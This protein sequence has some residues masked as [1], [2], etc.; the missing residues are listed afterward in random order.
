MVS[1][2]KD[3]RRATPPIKSLRDR[4]ARQILQQC[5]YDKGVPGWDQYYGY[6]VVL[7]YCAVINSM[8][9]TNTNDLQDN[10]SVSTY[11]NPSTG[12]ITIITT[13][14]YNVEIIIT[15]MIGEK[16]FSNNKIADLEKIDLS[17]QPN[18][19]YFIHVNSNNGSI[20]KKIIINK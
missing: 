7:A 16:L 11:P 12:I 10:I 2:N 3:S 4:Q 19:V 1:P 15:N 14:L 5:V 6:G 17:N 20:I 18:G 8:I 9:I 13:G